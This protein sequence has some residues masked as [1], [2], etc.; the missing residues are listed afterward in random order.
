[1]LNSP[2]ILASFSER[3]IHIFVGV[4]PRVISFLISAYFF[5]VGLGSPGKLDVITL[6]KKYYR[7]IAY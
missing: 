5:V 7:K 4:L 6:H 3:R 1:M 2:L